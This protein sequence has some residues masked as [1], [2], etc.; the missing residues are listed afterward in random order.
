MPTTPTAQKRKPRTR[1]KHVN[2]RPALAVSELPPHHLDLRPGAMCLVC[3]DCTTWCPITGHHGNTPKLVPH[4]TQPAGEPG[5]IRCTA[6]SNRRV[7]L[8]LTPHAWHQ[9]LTE[10]QEQLR[11]RRSNTTERPQ[12]RQ[13]PKAPALSVPHRR[14]DA[15]TRAHGTLLQHLHTCRQC[16]TGHTCQQGRTLLNHKIRLAGP[17]TTTEPTR[18]EYHRA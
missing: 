9:R 16:N 4:H 11:T 15:Q 13:R 5:K 3:P 8:D 17:V 12:P 7:T 10:A 14:A 18:R 1:T 6:G 2:N